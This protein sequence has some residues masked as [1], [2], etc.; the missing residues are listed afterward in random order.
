MPHPKIKAGDVLGDALAA[1]KREKEVVALL[2]MLL[3]VVFLIG[4]W[5]VLGTYTLMT[6]GKGDPRE[7]V[8][9]MA[10]DILE[11][12]WYLVISVILYLAAL[13]A[14]MVIWTRTAVLGRQA[15]LAG[16]V[17]QLTRRVGWTFWRYVCGLGWTL[18]FIGIAILPFAAFSKGGGV[19]PTSAVA[20]LLLTVLLGL[21]LFLAVLPVSM[22]VP[23]ACHG[24]AR[25]FHLP[26]HRAFKLMRGNLARAAGLLFL[27]I[28][29]FEIGI[30]TVF[31]IFGPALLE[32]GGWAMVVGNLLFSAVGYLLGFAI[33]A[34]GAYFAIRVVPEL[35]V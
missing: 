22:L 13:F 1:C 30:G 33:S 24:E 34:Y 8:R 23:I 20:I 12:R 16:G 31:M 21:V 15:A 28:L 19:A 29:L 32:A 18:L 26:I 10:E 35:K 3:G 4:F 17:V 6:I 2:A 5:P 25:D 27:V 9:V 11:N 7:L 14:I